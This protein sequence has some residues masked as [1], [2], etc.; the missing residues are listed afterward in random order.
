MEILYDVF[1]IHVP[2]WTNDF[3]QALVSVGELLFLHLKK[4]HQNCMNNKR[5]C[6]IK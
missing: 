4:Y 3:S 1:R 5:K 2:E 6:R